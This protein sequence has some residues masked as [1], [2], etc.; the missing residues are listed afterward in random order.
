MT[1]RRP[2][3]TIYL[4]YRSVLKASERDSSIQWKVYEKRAFCVKM[5]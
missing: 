3:L 5:V 4:Q 2:F 1:S